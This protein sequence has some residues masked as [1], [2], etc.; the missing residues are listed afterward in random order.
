MIAQSLKSYCSDEQD[1]WS[2][3]LP[4]I[5]MLFR[6]APNTQSI[7]YSPFYTLFGRDMSLPLDQSLISTLKLDKT[8]KE[9]VDDLIKKIII[10]QKYAK[11]NMEKEQNIS[12]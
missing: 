5:M 1:N 3:Y 11:E 9:Y 10:V 2:D 12:K 8:P 6:A 7:S 4:S